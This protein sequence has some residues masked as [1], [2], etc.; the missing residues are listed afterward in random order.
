MIFV[1]DQSVSRAPR[2]G[3]CCRKSSAAAGFNVQTQVICAGHAMQAERT[4]KRADSA[5]DGVGSL[6]TDSGNQP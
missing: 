2:Q 1:I 3:S 5:D 4:A 6:M